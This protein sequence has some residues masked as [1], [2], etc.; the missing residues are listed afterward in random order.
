VIDSLEGQLPPLPQG[1]AMQF[2][3]GVG[4]DIMRSDFWSFRGNYPRGG[5]FVE[6][7]PD[8]CF[9]ESPCSH[10]VVKRTEHYNSTKEWKQGFAS[11]FGLLLAG[12][13]KGFEASFDLSMSSSFQNSWPN[14]KQVTHSYISRTKKC[15]QFRSECLTNPE[16]LHCGF[17]SLLDRLPKNM[18]EENA[19]GIWTIAI[20]KNFGTHIA[21]KSEHGGMIQA[22]MSNDAA[23]KISTACRSSEASLRLGFLQFMNPL[24]SG[25][26]GVECKVSDSCASTLKTACTAVGGDASASVA[27]CSKDVSEEQ[28]E[29][30]LDGAN[31]TGASSIIHLELI[32]ISEMLKQMG[33][34]EEGLV[35]EKAMEYH[36]CSGTFHTWNQTSSSCKCTLECQ[37]GGTLNE[38]ECTCSCPGDADHG[39]TGTYCSETYG[40]CVR[41]LGSSET[42][43]A[44]QQACVEGNVCGGIERS[45]QCGDTEV[46]CNRDEGGICCPLGSSCDCFSTGR[47][48]QCQQR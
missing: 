33:F 45:E 34:W 25:L 36:A 10:A 22:T 15:Y 47:F 28:I 32:P 6:S 3:I 12:A 23:C 39:F 2:S 30:F 48:C 42:L 11:S 19:L 21:V 1:Y 31:A 5:V 40:K 17:R 4:F 43:T 14:D 35:V 24:E 41:G 16:Y 44:R 38:E 18:T 9:T 26:N 37:N 13:Y 8:T 7:I 29:S 27:M 20:L 46:C